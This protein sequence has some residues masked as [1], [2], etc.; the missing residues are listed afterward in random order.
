MKTFVVVST[1]MSL[2]PVDGSVTRAVGAERLI[3]ADYYRVMD[4]ALIFRTEARG[5]E[6][7]NPAVRV[8]APGYWAEVYE[9]KTLRERVAESR[10]EHGAREIDFA[11]GYCDQSYGDPRDFQ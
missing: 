1:V 2:H 3:E 7:Y 5:N 4:G 11:P 6:K 8:F 9:K 10:H